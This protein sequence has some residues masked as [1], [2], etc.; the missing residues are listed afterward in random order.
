LGIA[1]YRLGQIE[2]A[3]A[4]L[5]EA[6][7]LERI[8][9]GQPDL[10]PYIQAYLAMTYNELGQHQLATKMLGEF[11]SIADK[12]EDNE[13]TQRLRKTV[14]QAIGFPNGAK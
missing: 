7:R 6:L 11:N 1:Q 14:S 13:E 9:Y 12:F 4:S 10:Q 5:E 8:E 3:K 2:D